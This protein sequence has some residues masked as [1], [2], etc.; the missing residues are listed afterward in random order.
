VEP[1]P[2]AASATYRL[3]IVSEAGQAVETVEGLT[4]NSYGAIAANVPATRLAPGSY[5]AQLYSS[6]G[7]AIVGEYR[8]TIQAQK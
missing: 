1:P 4:R 2:A 6:A 8:F 3:T 5:R 7:P